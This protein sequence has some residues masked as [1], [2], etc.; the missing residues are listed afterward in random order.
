[1]PVFEIIKTK[2][3][4]SETMDRIL[5]PLYA[6]QDKAN[7]ILM[8]IQDIFITLIQELDG[9]ISQKE[10]GKVINSGYYKKDDITIELKVWKE[11]E[12]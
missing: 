9:S 10:L 3:E 4:V 6:K 1:M 7:D 11:Q 2:N 12:K 8:Q 5:L